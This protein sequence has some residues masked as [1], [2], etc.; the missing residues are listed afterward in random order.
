MIKS[1]EA[2]KNAL[3]QVAQLM[4]LAARTAPKAKGVDQ[5]DTL[6]LKE[7]A[8]IA[9]LTAGMRAIAEKNPAWAFFDRDANCLEKADGPVVIIGTKKGNLGMNCGFCGFPTCA[10]L[11]KAGGACAV[12]AGD[13]GIA[14]GSAVS[15]A[16]QHKADNR[17]MFSIGKTAV[18]QKLF[19][20]DIKIAYG[21]P[22]SAHGKNPFFD[23]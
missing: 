10:D 4:C 11:V 21:M 17:V 12:T 14:I 19:D 3:E 16:A 22:L 6:I 5:V 8:D 23:R 18:D 15:V 9:K 20:E 1:S 2:E 7:P 13:L